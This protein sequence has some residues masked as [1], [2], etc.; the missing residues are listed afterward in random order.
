MASGLELEEDERFLRRSWRAERAGWAL[1]LALIAASLLGALAPGAGPVG[2]GC[3]VYL[4]LL[5]VF[6]L[7]GKRSLAQTTTF[8]LVLLLIISEVT[9]QAMVGEDKTMA[10]AFVLIVTLVGLDIAFSHLKLRSPLFDRIVED[11]PL[12]V[13]ARGKPLKERMA[14]ERITE[15]DILFAARRDHG[16]ERLDQIKYAVLETSGEISII[17]A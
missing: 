1:M 14:K 6:R 8:D 7:A 12:V 16:L 5:L 10:N 13:L 11:I 17:P 2:R 4:F 15:E 3:A 9:Q